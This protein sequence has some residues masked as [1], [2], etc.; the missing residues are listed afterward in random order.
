MFG[1][2]CR[3]LCVALSAAAAIASGAAA[4]AQPAGVAVRVA[5]GDLDFSS[6][7]DVAVFRQRVDKAA[8]SLCTRES[9]LDVLEM[10]ACQRA[11][12]AQCLRNL[13]DVQRRQLLA[14]TGG[15]GRPWGGRG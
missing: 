6:A 1:S 3:V 10:T 9:Q 4:S 15:V 8:R 11:I 13:S 7:R 14:T 12:R 2:S 5:I